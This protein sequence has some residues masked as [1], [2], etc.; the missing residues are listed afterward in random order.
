MNLK[1]WKKTIESN[2]EI[3]S[4][5]F[6]NINKVDKLLAKLTKESERSPKLIKLET[7]YGHF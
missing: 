1:E 3:K 2:C 5:F 6:E 7:K 4:W